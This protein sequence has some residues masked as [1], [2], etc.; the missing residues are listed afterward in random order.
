MLGIFMPLFSCNTNSTWKEYSYPESFFRASFPNSPEARSQNLPF[1]GT[2]L[3]ITQSIY[4]ASDE[5]GS[6]YSIVFNVYPEEIENIPLERRLSGAM[7][8]ILSR[9]GT[10]LLANIPSKIDTFIA[11]DCTFINNQIPDKPF[12][13]RVKTVS[14]LRYAFML[15][16]MDHKKDF[17]QEKA[18]KFFSSFSLTL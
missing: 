3:S 9:P 10:S 6:N 11:S 16:V 17:N 14:M 13:I 12:I 5:D 8:G 18:N 1:P 7:D 15:S 4:S 2:N